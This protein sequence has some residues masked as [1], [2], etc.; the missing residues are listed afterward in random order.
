MSLSSHHFPNFDSLTCP[1]SILSTWDELRLIGLS[2]KNQQ[3][4]KLILSL[5]VWRSWTRDLS[6]LKGLNSHCLVNHYLCQRAMNIGKGI[7]TPIS[8]HSCITSRTFVLQIHPH[9]STSSLPLN[10][11]ATFLPRPERRGRCSE[12]EF[13]ILS[14]VQRRRFLPP[15]RGWK[16]G[17]WRGEKSIPDSIQSIGDGL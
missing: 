1:Q 13:L 4:E 15:A 16:P 6:G 10:C 7:P 9:A 12:K 14:P 17:E 11:W 8:S 2:P 3:T 5:I